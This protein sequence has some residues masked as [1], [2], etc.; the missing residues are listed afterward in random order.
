MSN[1]STINIPQLNDLVDRMFLDK[2]ESLPQEFRKSGLVVVET[3]PEGTGGYRRLA[4][5]PDRDLYADIRDEGD[6]S[7]QTPIQIGWE[8]DLVVYDVAKDV[9]IT[10]KERRENKYPQVV[11]KLTDLTELAFN[12][13]ELDLAHRFSFAYSTSYTDKS[14]KTIDVTTG[15][16]LAAAS[17]VHALTGSSTTYSTIITANPVFSKAA[18]ELAQRSATEES[19]SNLGQKISVPFDIIWTTDNRQTINAVQE[20]LNATADV[21]SSNAGTFN[22]YKGAMRH[23]ILSR[24]ATNATGGVDTSKRLYWGIASSKATDLRMGIIAEPYMRMPA[25]GNNGADF[26][27][28][29]W[30]YGVTASYGICMVTARGFRFSNG[31]GS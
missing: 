29:N 8:K 5:M 17:A 4:E 9:T 11:A 20:L 27:S 23:V 26:S 22:V 7:N 6:V 24:V 18:L 2:K 16:G 13:M 10:V 1:L 15:D 25:E 31:S 3:I 12:R 28:E 14:G 21:S 19:Y 30:T